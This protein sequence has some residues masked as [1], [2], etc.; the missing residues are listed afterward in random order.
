LN[1]LSYP[2]L[3]I[4]LIFLICS[5]ILYHVQEKQWNF[6]FTFVWNSIV[7]LVLLKFFIKIIT[8]TAQDYLKK[9][10]DMEMELISDSPLQDHSK[11]N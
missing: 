11:T 5:I 9:Q 2:P 1:D 3:I 10:Q 4:H 6:S 8:S 7:W